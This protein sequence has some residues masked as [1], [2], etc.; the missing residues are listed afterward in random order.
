MP[1]G[2]TF[3]FHNSEGN[4]LL[5]LHNSRGNNLL[6]LHISR[7]NNLLARQL[8]VRACERGVRSTFTQVFFKRTEDFQIFELVFFL[9]RTLYLG[10]SYR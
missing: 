8:G 3:A 9:A 6:A 4:N 7:G 10:H 5:A 1:P 2:K